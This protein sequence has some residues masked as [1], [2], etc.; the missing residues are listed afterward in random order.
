[1]N[2]YGHL[3]QPP[4]SQAPVTNGKLV[5]NLGDYGA[6]FL[7]TLKQ[8]GVDDVRNKYYESGQ[9]SDLDFVYTESA[10]QI[11]IIYE[12]DQVAFLRKL[13][14]GPDMKFLSHIASLNSP[15]IAN[16]YYRAYLEFGLGINFQINH[17][18]G[19]RT[20]IDY[21]LEAAAPNYLVLTVCQK[22]L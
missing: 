4:I 13:Q 12:P 19:A 2:F 3:R 11:L 8:I 1:M 21:L 9:R 15:Q 22:T 18:L 16:A 14:V 10:S 7:H 20:D 6:T 17:Y 5:L